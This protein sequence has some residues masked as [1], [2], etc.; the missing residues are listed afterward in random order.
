VKQQIPT[1][2]ELVEVAGLGIWAKANA[3]S[4]LD[5]ADGEDV[6]GVQGRD[7]SGQEVD[8]TG[9]VT[10]AV[11]VP[12]AECVELVPAIPSAVPRGLDL[13]TPQLPTCFDDNVVSTILLYGFRDDQTQGGGPRHKIQL[14]CFTCHVEVKR[15]FSHLTLEYQIGGGKPVTLLQVYTCRGIIS[16]ARK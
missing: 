6:P 15:A 5:F 12:V 7:I 1:L 3:C 10:P 11:C 4:V 13:H 9:L 8:F 2:A 16:L 14:G